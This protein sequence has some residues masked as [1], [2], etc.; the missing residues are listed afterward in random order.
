MLV[1][2]KHDPL[3]PANLLLNKGGGMGRFGLKRVLQFFVVRGLYV[4]AT[5]Q[6]CDWMFSNVL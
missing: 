4:K 6:I 3:L 2:K 5:V 1:F